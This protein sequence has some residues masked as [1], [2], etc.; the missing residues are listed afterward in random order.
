MLPHH[1]E[2]LNRVRVKLEA[3]PDV[4][5]V[6]LVGSIAHGFAKPGSDVDIMA[7]LPDDK[8]ADRAA[9]GALT[10]L[11]FDSCTYE[12]GYVD[13]K[14]TSPLLMARVAER[15]SE[16]ARF[17]YE[18]ASVVFSRDPGIDALLPRIARYP[19]ENKAEN[20]KRFFAQLKAWRWYCDEAVKHDN[21]YLLTHSL[22]N[23]ILFGGR[24]LL[25]HNEVLYP[26]HKWFLK[27]LSGVSDKPDGVMEMIDV[28]LRTRDIGDIAR[29]YDAIETFA[30]WPDASWSHQFVLDCEM[31]WMSGHTP[32]TDL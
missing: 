7:V 20:L 22:N 17:A 32:V 4:L 15:G 16:P 9:Q 2:T 13:G 19:V 5:A 25:A 26:Y 6:L 14:Y 3:D 29:L 10:F 21:L 12:N 18:G 11:D 24:L 8:H 28:A 1:L 30:A 31:N 23:L 27:V